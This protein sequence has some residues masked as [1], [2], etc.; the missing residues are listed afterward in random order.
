MHFTEQNQYMKKKFTSDQ[1][2]VKCQINE[3]ENGRQKVQ[4]MWGK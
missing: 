4:W 3:N 2:E 1:D